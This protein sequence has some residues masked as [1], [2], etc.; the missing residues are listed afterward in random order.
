MF[1]AVKDRGLPV[2]L[3]VFHGEGHGFRL[4]SNIR[5]ALDSELSFLGQVWGLTPGD[6]DLTPITVENLGR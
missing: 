1:Q 4:A 6:E 2:A 3:Q 5:K